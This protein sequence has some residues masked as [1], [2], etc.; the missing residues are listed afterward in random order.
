MDADGSG[1]ID[2]DEF[3]TFLWDMENTADISITEADLS[4]YACIALK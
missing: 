2:W 3:M 4:K 1:A